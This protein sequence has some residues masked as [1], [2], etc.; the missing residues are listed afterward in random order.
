MADP[1]KDFAIYMEGH[2]GHRGN[3]LAHAWI[4]KV[5]KLLSV[6][7]RMERQFLDVAKRKTVFEVTD[8]QKRNPTI[9]SLK[10]VP[11]V[12][13]YDPL[14]AFQW[15]LD[16]LENVAASRPVDPRVDA[17]TADMIASLAKAPAEEAYRRFWINGF[18]DPVEFND[19]FALN[20]MTLAAQRRSTQ[21]EPDWFVGVSQGSV[22]GNLQAIDDVQGDRT[23]VLVPAIG[24]SQIECQFPE[25]MRDEMGK[26]VFK[27]VRV[28]GL[29]TYT[30]DSPFPSKV[31]MESIDPI[32]AAKV[33]MVDLEGLFRGYP[34]NE[35]EYSAWING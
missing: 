31:K 14:P 20:A 9:I 12:V 4:E 11:S 10:P 34:K 8:T 17:E 22:T 18:A 33:H 24:P 26:H 15:T 21:A 1:L 32:E 2:E 19:A 16:Q 6:L 27:A 3:V 13:S 30:A 7:A 23:F 28:S 29:L 35:P 5:G 25:N